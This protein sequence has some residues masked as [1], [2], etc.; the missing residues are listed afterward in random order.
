MSNT[1]PVPERR[2]DPADWRGVVSGQLLPAAVAHVRRARSR[3]LLRAAGDSVAIALAG[4][5]LLA[6]WDRAAAL[7]AEVR[8]AGLLLVL[9]AA[10]ARALPAAAR[11]LAP[12][13]AAAAAREL[14]T[15]LRLPHESLVTLAWQS[16]RPAPG[17]SD[18]L[19]GA[20]A[21]DAAVALSSAAAELDRQ[22]G[23]PART[24]WARAAV[25]VAVIAVLGGI[26]SLRFPE[27]AMRVVMPWQDR[28]PLTGP[29]LR[30]NPGDVAVPQGRALRV[31]ATLEG[32]GEGP[33]Y[34]EHS[35]DGRAWS[36][37]EMSPRG[38]DGFVGE[39]PPLDRDVVYRV[40]YFPSVGGLPGLATSAVSSPAFAARVSTVP[41]LASAALEVVGPVEAGNATRSLVP[42]R[43]GRATVRS[44]G[45]FKLR[46]SATEDLAGGEIRGP[47]FEV[48]LSPE[49]A[50]PTSAVAVL[51]PE[52]S[53]LAT[54]ELNL[55]L[56]ARR[57]GV[58]T[59]RLSITFMPDAAPVALLVRP[60]EGFPAG[61]RDDL[62]VSISAEDDGGLASLRVELS[63]P[64]G[65]AQSI[66]LPLS[67]LPRQAVVARRLSLGQLGLRAGDAVT[68]TAVARDSAGREG[69]SAPTH[70]TITGTAPDPLSGVRVEAL[71][72]LASYADRSRRA[73]SDAA[74]LLNQAAAGEPDVGTFATS[75]ALASLSAASEDVVRV[76]RLAGRAA[77]VAASPE[78][79]DACE[80]LADRAIG[81]AMLA[82]AALDSVGSGEHAALADIAARAVRAAEAMGT[83]RSS[84]ET[85]LKG[86]VAALL[87]GS[88][89]A[90]LPASVRTSDPRLTD[91]TDD[92]LKALIDE[93]AAELAR[94]VPPDLSSVAVSRDGL[95]PVSARLESAWRIESLRPDGQPRRAADLALAA[96][97]AAVLSSA[98][99]LPTE[100]ADVLS[101][102]AAHHA[103]LRQGTL[104]PPAIVSSA[105]AAR[106]RLREWVGPAAGSTVVTLESIADAR[107][108]GRPPPGA[109]GEDATRRSEELASLARQQRDLAGEVA[110]V[111]PSPDVGVTESLAAALDVI[112]RRLPAVAGGNPEDRTRAYRA[113]IDLIQRLTPLVDAG[114][115]SAEL[116]GLSA[117][118]LR[119]SLRRFMPE[120]ASSV[121]AVDRRL[122]PAL[123]R[124]RSAGDDPAA[125]E[126]AARDVSAALRRVVSE[127]GQARRA[128]TRR[129]PISAARASIGAAAE[130]L[131]ASDPDLT[132]AARLCADA[133]TALDTALTQSLRESADRLLSAMPEM[134]PYFAPMR[135]GPSGGDRRTATRPFAAGPT[136][137][138]AYDESGI[139][140]EYRSGVRAYFE[141]LERMTPEEQP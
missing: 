111:A 73:L 3:S 133:S 86:E 29:R 74:G 14:E 87:L 7:P 95:V 57:G 26:P 19:L 94:L 93:A 36:R 54:C 64:A 43:D 59:A 11:R 128:M 119:Q 126:A 106:V 129:D 141:R 60:A 33:V 75:L 50:E 69:R 22:A 12:V 10:V 77:R 48:A 76:S 6:I 108:Q 130:S 116:T 39:L 135:V 66:E 67:G 96:R 37:T 1:L 65:P 81:P 134:T 92:A 52:V 122:R 114:A 107:E 34:L 17:V 16:T 35:R 18:G 62:E 97:A 30:V 84:V 8:A 25:G 104:S 98:G 32:G 2:D 112:S 131:R 9:G 41:A 46:V 139:P 23:P 91:A 90:P 55:T 13:S 31:A 100:F 45:G 44:G 82:E 49:A 28:E 115:S 79:A 21:S 101:S 89:T 120:F 51:P 80:A 63:G 110:A 68:I 56:R 127:L 4:V 121:S 72:A 124:L 83:L 24:S 117:D 42:F 99:G 137:A 125:R 15:A 71:S 40:S 109:A 88:R 103:S 102:L 140:P 123:E 61:P 47:G 105:E 132:T 136:T 20:L 58:G 53:S 113:A 138:P 118:E 38:A 85:L 78:F 5:A 27:A 70:L